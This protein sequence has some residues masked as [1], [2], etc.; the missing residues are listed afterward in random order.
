SPLCEN[1]TLQIQLGCA[2]TDLSTFADRP[3]RIW[4]KPRSCHGRV[5]CP[6]PAARRCPFGLKAS[7]FTLLPT[8]W[9]ACSRS[10]PIL[11]SRSNPSLEPLASVSP[12]GENAR[13]S[14]WSE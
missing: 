10:E 13:H 4:T 7:A 3:S 2:V 14:T 8:R 9:L 6:Q 11:H 1:A 5:G 12:S